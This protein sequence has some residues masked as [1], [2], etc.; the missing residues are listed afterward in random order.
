MLLHGAGDTRRDWHKTGYV[1]RLRDEFTMINVDIR[2][3]GENEALTRIEDYSIQKIVNDLREVQDCCG[4]HQIMVWGYSFGGNIAR[5][6]GAWSDCVLAIAVIGVPFGRVVNKAFDSY[7]DV[8]I[9][10]Y[11]ALAQAY[12]EDTLSE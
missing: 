5:Y 10:K 8:F 11:C 3:S 12:K 7:I 1:D 4:V 6:L 2:G 9:E